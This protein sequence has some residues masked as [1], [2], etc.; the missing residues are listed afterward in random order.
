MLMQT[1]LGTYYF[2]DGKPDMTAVC[3]LLIL[4]DFFSALQDD[5][6]LRLVEK[7]KEEAATA[8]TPA[9]C[10][11]YARYGVRQLPIPE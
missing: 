6:L 7:L 9:N 3:G 10:L 11:T 5:D 8:I 1:I 4:C 2:F